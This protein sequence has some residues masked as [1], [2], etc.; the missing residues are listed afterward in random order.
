MYNL[1]G[2]AHTKVRN[3]K[4]GENKMRSN[5]KKKT[6]KACGSRS[7]KACG[8][9]STKASGSRSTKASGSRATHD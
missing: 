9:R 8:S 7:T 3:L 5:D 1:A 4:K 2:G 6:A